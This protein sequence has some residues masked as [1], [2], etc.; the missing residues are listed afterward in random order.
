[1]S[2]IIQGKIYQRID[3]AGYWLETVIVSPTVTA[4]EDDTYEIEYI[5]TGD[6]IEAD[7]PENI[8]SRWDGNHWQLPEIVIPPMPDPVMMRQINQDGYFISD[9]IIIPE[10]IDNS[11]ISP[12]CDSADYVADIVPSDAGFYRPR[13]VNGRWVEGATK[14]EMAPPKYPDWGKFIIDFTASSLDEM[15]AQPSNNTNVLRLNRLLSMYPNLSVPDVLNAWNQCLDGLETPPNKDQRKELIGV[16]E[17][18][19]LPVMI[20]KNS[21]LSEVTNG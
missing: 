8:E 11:W 4:L 2:N 18:C 12:G 6:L 5:T 19:N 10:L 14:A 13:W 15:I 9:V 1:M 21:R 17:S 20:D 16:I 3:G 7:V